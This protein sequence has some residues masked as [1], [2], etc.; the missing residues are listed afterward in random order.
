MT[1]LGRRATGPGD[2]YLTGGTTAVLFGWR[3][4]TVDADLKLDP[5]PSGI[6]GAIA[7]LKDSLDINI[8]LAC[9]ADFIPELPAWR[10]HSVFIDKRGPVRFFHYDLRAQALAKIERGH[11]RDLSDVRAMFRE[12]LVDATQLR[13]AFSAIEPALERY[14][15][16]D[17]EVFREKL[18]EI[19]AAIEA[20]AKP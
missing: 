9:P 20:E 7:W 19:L 3:D 17:A 14:P 11:G 8:E 15:A 13:A 16:L 18:E 10:E 12:G 2:I 1:E 4:S 6:F 5:E